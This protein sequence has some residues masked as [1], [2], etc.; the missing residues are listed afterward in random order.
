MT[1]F[2]SVSMMILDLGADGRVGD[3][4]EGLWKRYYQ[5]LVRLAR[6]RLSSIGK[7]SND[8]EDVALNAFHS[9]YKAAE[10][11]RFPDLTDRD[12]LWRLLFR[13]TARKVIDL[14]RHENRIRRGGGNELGESALNP[15]DIENEL[16]G[17]A[18]VVG[19]EPSPEF[20]AMM[21]ERCA[22]LLTLLGTKH[23]ALPAIAEDK[24]AGFSNEE[25]AER[26]KCGMRTVE[27]RL[28]L[29]RDIWKETLGA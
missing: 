1:E 10:K 9:F 11:G 27:R 24:L 4:Q 7:S 3:A 6:D 29:I 12:G 16:E 22:E 8:A 13:I 5:K 2:G 20:V 25:I 18:N 21:D 23:E 17:M 28:K 15:L 14:V 26:Q 19:D